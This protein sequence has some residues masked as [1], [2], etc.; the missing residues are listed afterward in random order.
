MSS[1]D[2]TNRHLAGKNKTR[3][4]SFVILK[5]TCYEHKIGLAIC[6]NF[7]QRVVIRNYG[8]LLHVAVPGVCRQTGIRV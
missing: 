5:I 6:T 1:F 2:L 7:L 3:S 8:K 4:F